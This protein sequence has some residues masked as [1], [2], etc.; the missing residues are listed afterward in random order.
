VH[1][2]Y[3]AL[4]SNIGD[5]H[6]TLRRA[7][8][9][10]DRCPAVT[11]KAVSSFIET[12]PVGGPP[13]GEYVNAAAELRVSLPPAALLDVLL[14]VE[15]HFGRKRLIRWGPRTLDLDLLLYD[16]VVCN[17]AN[18]QIP[19]PRMHERRFVLAPL[20]EIAPDVRHPILGRSVRELLADLG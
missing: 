4:G 15:A 5:R 19:H 13:Q 12:K 18:L 7:L 6:D 3:I 16:D 20:C 17:E 11:V 2:A 9:R 14:A 1:T 10:L 8:D